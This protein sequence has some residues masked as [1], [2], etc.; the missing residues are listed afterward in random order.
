MKYHVRVLCFFLLAL[1]IIGPVNAAPLEERASSSSVTTLNEDQLASLPTARDVNVTAL[2][3]DTGP[4]LPDVSGTQI[5]AG[6]K[7]SVI[8]LQT[9]PTITNN[10]YRQTL[11]KTPGLLVSE[12]TTPLFSVG[13]R[14]LD[15]H[16]GQFMQMLKDGF[17]IHADMF[18]YPESYYTPIL[19]TVD[20]INF[21]RGGAALMYGPQPGGALNY[22]THNPVTDRPLVLH[23]ENVFG[24]D[25]YFSNYDS[26]SGTLGSVG[27]LAYFHKRQ[28]DGFR[29]I[30]SDFDVIS[31]GIKVTINQTGDSR[32]TLTYDEYHEE[33]GEPGGLSLTT[34]ANSTYEENRDFT[35]RRYD[36][37]RL[38]RYYGTLLYEKEFSEATQ[39][40]LRLYGGHY[41]RY[42]RRQ[43]GGGFGTTPTGSAASTNSIEEQ[44]FYN[45]GF[46]PRIR[47]D[48]DLLGE[49]HTVTAGIHSFLAHSPRMD[50]LGNAPHAESGEIRKH[51]LR[52]IWYLSF[53]LENL[54]RIGKLSITPGVRLENI[55]QRIEEKRN[56]DKTTTPL[57]DES[58]F[59]FVPLFGLG[60]AYEIAKGIEAYAN[61]SQ[62]YRPKI[63][64]QAVPTGT[65]TVVPSD[66]EEGFAWQ[67]DIGLRGNPTPFFSWDV[68]YFILDFDN[69]IGNSGNTVTNIGDT[70][71]QG[72]ELFTEVDLIG[73]YDWLQNTHHGERLGSFA[74]FVTL[75]VLEAEATSG[76]NADRQTQYAP[77]YNLRFGI[78]YQWHDR[79]KI[80][81]MSTFLDDHFADSAETPNR[82]I[83]S[84]KVWDLTGE[85]NLLRNAWDKFDLSVFGGINNL[86]DENYYARIRGD[87][88]D[89]AY[90]RNIYGGVKVNLG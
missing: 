81:L 16:R 26:M 52:N 53:F 62:S 66:L 44:D 42:S 48:Y 2:K 17:P 70:L 65:N 34:T 79:V 32:L 56:L 35:T 86:F 18:G 45:I 37:F 58:I 59:D 73:A 43:R 6:K 77:Q 83:P 85:V 23:S 78:N 74:P 51:S 22:I 38:E 31:S 75:T 87:G 36:R 84:Y 29:E 33:H 40:D 24:S 21:I 9:L 13:Y 5:Y 69:Q 25:N 30:N 50:Q 60:I 12:E 41:R 10:N 49:T 1:Q 82:R 57:A 15:P 8:D 71:H 46:E 28:G 4:F 76:A 20:Q 7:T 67:Y 47:H 89:P 11:V 61:V 27:Y 63:F 80:S 72:M 68:S 90:G 55:W 64:T 88:I 3:P 19:Q 39:M 14:G 54:F